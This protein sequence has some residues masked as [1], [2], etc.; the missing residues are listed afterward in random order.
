MN[1]KRRGMRMGRKSSYIFT[2]KRHSQKAVMSTVFGAISTVSF[3]AT[4]YLTYRKEGNATVSYG[5]AGLLITIFSLTGL[6]LGIMAAFE[7]DRYHL[8][9]YLG[10]GLN[11]LIL[12]GI[13]F[14]LYA[15]A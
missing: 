11:I 6:I 12:A 14:I 15:A 4:I 10:I 3:L 2:N 8:F 5:V 9:D 1:R 7:K 13:S